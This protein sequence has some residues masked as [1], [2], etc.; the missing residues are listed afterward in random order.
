[1]SFHLRGRADAE[2]GTDCGH[3]EVLGKSPWGHVP[4]SYQAL[5]LLPSP[6]HTPLPPH[7][8]VSADVLL[9]RLASYLLRLTL[10]FGM[11]SRVGARDVWVRDLA[12]MFS[13][14]SMTGSMAGSMT[15]GRGR[16]NP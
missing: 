6:V 8:L 10:Y 7:L 9:P 11:L 5:G 15:G 14:K 1:M 3:I 12:P 16:L 4:H 13:G 2:T